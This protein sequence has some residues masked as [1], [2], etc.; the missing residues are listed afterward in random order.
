MV[1]NKGDVLYLDSENG[2]R[3]KVEVININDYREPSMKYAIDLVQEN[4]ARYTDAY[5]DY[6]FVGQ[7][8][9]DKCYK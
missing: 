9:I 5:G 1:V 8:F 4:G 3:Y 2:L 7:D 6:A